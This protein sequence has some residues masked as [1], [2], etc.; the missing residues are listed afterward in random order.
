MF[1][2]NVFSNQL[3]SISPECLHCFIFCPVNVW[4]D[5]MYKCFIRPFSPLSLLSTMKWRTRI[6]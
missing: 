3:D 5:E 2:V 1:D 6:N 4:G